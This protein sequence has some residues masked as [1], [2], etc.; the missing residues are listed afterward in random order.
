M[1]SVKA[2][3]YLLE[4]QPGNAHVSCKA[5]IQKIKDDKTTVG[6]AGEECLTNIVMHY[7]DLLKKRDKNE[8]KL[9]RFDLFK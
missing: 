6:I 9:K 8:R 5:L 3:E 1:Y 7:K 4:N 2:P